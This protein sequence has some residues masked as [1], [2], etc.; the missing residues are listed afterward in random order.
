MKPRSRSIPQ[1]QDR[2]PPRRAH[3]CPLSAQDGPPGAWLPRS[4][5]SAVGS[6]TWQPFPAALATVGDSTVSACEISFLKFTAPQVKQPHFRRKTQFI[7]AHVW[8]NGFQ[9][10]E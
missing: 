2:C 3:L 4:S 10:Y 7:F 9:R 5:V 6:S 1:A 8:K